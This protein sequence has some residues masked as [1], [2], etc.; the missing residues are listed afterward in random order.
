[1]S[2]FEGTTGRNSTIQTAKEDKLW[3]S[4]MNRNT[5]DGTSFNV[6][7]E[8]NGWQHTFL[9]RNVLFSK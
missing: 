2:S 7:T 3:K 4:F 9:N 5:Q 1:M 8:P 6:E